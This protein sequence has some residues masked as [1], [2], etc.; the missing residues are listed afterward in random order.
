[1]SPPQKINN[2]N[3]LEQAIQEREALLIEHPHLQKYQEQIDESIKNSKTPNQRLINIAK[4]SKQIRANRK[5]PKG[6]TN[7]E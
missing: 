4:I 7:K 1:M 2:S 3:F 6:I 5:L